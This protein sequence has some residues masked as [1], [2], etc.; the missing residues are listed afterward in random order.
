MEDP[1]D[2]PDRDDDEDKKQNKNKRM[3]PDD[4]ADYKCGGK[5]PAPREDSAKAPPR[6][7]PARGGQKACTS[8]PSTLRIWPLR[9]LC[10]G[11]WS[12]MRVEAFRRD[13]ACDTHRCT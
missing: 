11:E 13:T 12:S 4:D 6:R 2:E 7:Q 1:F 3:K 8:G 10:V 5:Q 9:L